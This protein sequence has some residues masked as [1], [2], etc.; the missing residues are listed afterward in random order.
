MVNLEQYNLTSRKDF[1]RLKCYLPSL[2]KSP[3]VK[4]TGSGGVK[5]IHEFI[6]LAH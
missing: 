4:D 5:S 2:E 3:I 6:E 1:K